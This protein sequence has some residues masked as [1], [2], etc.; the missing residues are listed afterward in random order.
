MARSC[1]GTPLGAVARLGAG[2]PATS[3]ASR[4]PAGRAALGSRRRASALAPVAPHRPR[5]VGD[6]RS[7]APP[8]D[9]YHACGSLTIA[10]RSARDGPAA[11][12]AGRRGRHLRRHRRRLGIQQRPRHARRSG[13][14]YAP[15]AR[16]ARRPTPDHRQRAARRASRGRAGA[17]TRRRSPTTR[18]S[19]RTR[20]RRRSDRTRRP[21]L[22][23]RPPRVGHRIVLFQGRLGPRLGLDAAA[24]AVLAMPDAVLVPARLRPRASTASRARDADPRFAAATTRSRPVHPDELL[25]WT[26]RRCRGRAAAARLGQSAA[27]EA[28][29]ALGGARRRDAGRRRSRSPVMGRLV[30]EHDLGAVARSLAP[31]DLAEAIRT[32]LDVTPAEAAGR[33]ARI[34]SIARDRYTWRIAAARYRKLV[35]ATVRGR[36]EQAE[37][38]RAAADARAELAGAGPPTASAVR[39]HRAT[40]GSGRPRTPR[41]QGGD[42]CPRRLDRSPGG[43]GGD[44]AGRSGAAL[45]AG[46]PQRRR[47]L[48]RV[49]GVGRGDARRRS[50]RLARRAAQ[51]PRTPPA[52][53]GCSNTYWS[54]ARCT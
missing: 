28:E 38:E 12:R 15:R 26:A 31:G 40:R 51:G 32:L 9:L 47:R 39:P 21:T 1:V 11:R 41:D 53:H 49:G 23:P 2:R 13:R 44:R 48:V 52:D 24:E 50:R 3:G 34:A 16:W 6:A 42:P 5:L 27:V 25:A 46:E 29:Q 54:Q 43:G 19:R 18:R 30:A 7:R 10:P 33:R 20:R 37:G 35:A 4:R 45:F 14:W 17:T 8:A 22:A 36:V